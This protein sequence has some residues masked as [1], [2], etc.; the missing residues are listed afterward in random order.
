MK[1][2]ESTE[3]N[4]YAEYSFYKESSRQKTVPEILTAN[5]PEF[6]RSA[7][8][9]NG[10]LTSMAGTVSTSTSFKEGLVSISSQCSLFVRDHPDF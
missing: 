9:L 8:R 4:N 5:S 10:N 7:E 3:G 6:N 2:V 1:W